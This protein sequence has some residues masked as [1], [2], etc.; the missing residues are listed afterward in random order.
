MEVSVSLCYPWTR[1]FYSRLCC[2]DVSV[3]QQ[4]VLPLDVSVIEQHAL[5]LDVSVIQQPACAGQ[6]VSGLNSSLC[7]T[8]SCLSTRACAAP[9]C[10]F[11]LHIEGMSVDKNLYCICVWAFGL[12]SLHLEGGRLQKPLWLTWTCRVRRAKKC[13]THADYAHAQCKENKEYFCYMLYVQ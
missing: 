11:L 1:L 5:A 12:L 8:W 2:L 10:A 9:A 7:C 6:E 3:I 13:L 4:P